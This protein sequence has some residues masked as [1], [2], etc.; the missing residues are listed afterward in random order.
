M[1]PPDCPPARCTGD[2]SPKQLRARA[3][4]LRQQAEELLQHAASLFMQASKRERERDDAGRT[5][6]GHDPAGYKMR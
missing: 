5:D 2:E 6:R 3:Q 4:A 1:A